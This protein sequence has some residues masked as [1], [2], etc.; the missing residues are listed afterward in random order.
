MAEAVVTVARVLSAD[1]AT[2]LVGT[3]VN[4]S[5]APTLASP[6]DGE[7]LRLVDA[8]DGETLGLVTRLPLGLR[9][10][11]REVVTGLTYGNDAARRVKVMQLRSR[12]FG[13]SPRNPLIRQE[14][15][16][17][18]RLARDEPEAEALL[19][20]VADHLSDEFEQLLPA[21]AQNDREV[22]SGS[23]LAE[24]RLGERSLWTSGVINHDSVLPYHRD[25]N[26]LDAWSAMPTLRYGM[27]G[28][29]LHLP[30]YGVVFPTGDGDVTWF[31]GRG[32]VHG[33]TDLYRRRPGGYR[34]SVVFYALARLRSC[35]SYA[36]ET[37]YSA[38]NR[39]ARERAMADE[40]RALI[41]LS[42]EPPT[43]GSRSTGWAPRADGDPALSG[44]G[45]NLADARQPGAAT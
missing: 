7:V 27:S 4:A 6:A 11:L 2:A 40:V 9:Q 10:G 1:E 18:S 43:A 24:W 33:V 25:A 44:L 35:A 22:V 31:Y 36:A 29:H 42:P 12:I 23:V 39:T 8:A 5:L 30:E 19:E 32:L 45:A 20:R 38:A 26:N 16:R 41:G 15:C 37:A 34:Y 28:G 3:P 17:A 14:A 21:R 13:Y